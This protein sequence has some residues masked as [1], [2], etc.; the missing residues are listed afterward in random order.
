MQGHVHIQI[1][2]SVI[3]RF[4]RVINNHTSIWIEEEKASDKIQ[5]QFIISTLKKLEI[6]GNF[7]HLKRGIFGK[8]WLLTSYLIVKTEKFLLEVN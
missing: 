1:S 8:N 2:I 3:H 4:N 7:L 5:H 6:E